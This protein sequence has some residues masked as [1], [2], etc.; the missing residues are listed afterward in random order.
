MNFWNVSNLLLT[1]IYVP[2]SISSRSLQMLPNFYCLSMGIDSPPLERQ[3]QLSEKWMLRLP[4]KMIFK[5]QEWPAKWPN[6]PCFPGLSPQK[7]WCQHVAPTA[8]TAP[9]Q[10]EG[11]EA[12]VIPRRTP[13]SMALGITSTETPP[14]PSQAPGAR[15]CQGLRRTKARA[16]RAAKSGD[17]HRTLEKKLGLDSCSSNYL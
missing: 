14:Q 13:T 8:P 12:E 16:I 1:L 2:P 5:N 17:G 6:R 3:R 9:T 15:R 7:I 4:R 10:L 11:S